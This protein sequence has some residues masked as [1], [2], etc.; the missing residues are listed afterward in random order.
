MFLQALMLIMNTILLAWL[1]WRVQH[2]KSL[3]LYDPLTGLPNRR[4]FEDRLEQA[5]KQARRHQTLAAVLFL[6]LDHFKQ[7]NDTQGHPVGDQLLCAVAQRLRGCVREVDTV[8]RR[9][10]DEFIVL[11]TDL[12][13][14]NAAA[15]VAQKIIT[16]L[17]EP[18]LIAARPLQISA[19]LGISLCDQKEATGPHSIANADSALYEAKQRGRGHYRFFTPAGTSTLAAA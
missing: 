16:A 3:A 13:D 15:R 10:G 2:F 6:D 12:T 4:L 19:S 14:P 18:F 1:L 7:I 5:V 8:A 9:G 11:L 17:H